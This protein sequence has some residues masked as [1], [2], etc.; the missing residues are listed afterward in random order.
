LRKITG[1]TT[2]IDPVQRP[3]RPRRAERSYVDDRGDAAEVDDGANLPVVVQPAPAPESGGLISGAAG[4]SAQILGQDGQK[5]GLRGGP[6]ILGNARTVY[7]RT[8]YSGAADRR[9][10]K[11][12]AAKTQV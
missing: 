8:E 12:G 5:R 3:P 4:F 1:M 10:P 2:P 7:T 11:G 6:E 9:A